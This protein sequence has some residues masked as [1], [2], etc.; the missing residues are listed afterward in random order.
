MT[1]VRRQL[2]CKEVR[3]RDT[4]VM[5]ETVGLEEIAKGEGVEREENLD[6]SLE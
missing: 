2:E 3:A 6:L 5:V 1:S 4:W